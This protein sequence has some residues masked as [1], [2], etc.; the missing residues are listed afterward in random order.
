VPS[1]LSEYCSFAGTC[2]RVLAGSSFMGGSL[3]HIATPLTVED[4]K[5]AESQA[6]STA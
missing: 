2:Q 3:E 5:E 1:S 4:E 6:G